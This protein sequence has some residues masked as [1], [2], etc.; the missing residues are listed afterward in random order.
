VA[1]PS[2]PGPG[3]TPLLPPLLPAPPLTWVFTE[4]HS[5]RPV[6]PDGPRPSGTVGSSWGFRPAWVHRRTAV[7]E[8]SFEPIG[9]Q[10]GRAGCGQRPGNCPPGCGRRRRASQRSGR[11]RAWHHSGRASG[12][13]VG[14][15]VVEWLLVGLAMGPIITVTKVVIQD[16]GSRWPALGM[17]SSF[18][19]L[20]GRAGARSQ[21]DAQVSGQQDPPGG[22]HH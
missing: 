19:P 1:R 9:T 22:G 14:P 7:S 15:P 11:R 3:I 20:P 13:D 10:R 12:D 4:S 5:L 2:S 17:L 6:V 8:T 21:V 18:A 16:P